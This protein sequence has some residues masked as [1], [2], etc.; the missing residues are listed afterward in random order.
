MCEPHIAILSHTHKL[1]IRVYD[2]AQALFRAGYK[3]SIISWQR[4][5]EEPYAPPDG[6]SHQSISAVS[7]SSGIYLALRIPYITKLFYEYLK[8]QDFDVLHITH[9]FFLP[10]CN[11][12]KRCKRFKI[13]YDAFD[14]YA[15]DLAQT[16]PLFKEQIC[17]A[18]ERAEDA[19]VRRLVDAVLTTGSAGGR[20]EKRYEACGATVTPVYNLPDLDRV[21]TVSLK[22]DAYPNKTRPSTLVYVGGI[23]DTKGLSVCLSVAQSLLRLNYDIRLKLIGIKNAKQNA[24]L[25]GLLERYGAKACV[26]VYPWMQYEE[27]LEHVAESDIGLALLQPTRSYEMVG[28]GTSRKIFTYLSCGVPVVASN[29]G[30]LGE[31]LRE[32]GA[33]IVTESARHDDVYCAIKYVLD[34]AKVREDMSKNAREIVAK[35]YNWGKE[36]DKVISVYRSLLG[37]KAASLSEGRYT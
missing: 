35:K 33:G 23:K 22:S 4:D 21:P 10:L 11:R 5:N 8:Q 12:L 2:Q 37:S 28:K 6:V 24:S 9:P 20:L 14:R 26:E 30:E 36:R 29:C 32:S 19:W 1:N 3:V 7:R 34:N 15:V 27:M 16:A 17:T 18:L 31:V 13:V 25:N